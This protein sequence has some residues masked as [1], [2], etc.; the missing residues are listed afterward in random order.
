MKANNT[1]YEYKW[2]TQEKVN[3]TTMATD[4]TDVLGWKEISIGLQN[5]WHEFGREQVE[6]IKSSWSSCYGNEQLTLVNQP[7]NM[8]TWKAKTQAFSPRLMIS[9][10]NNAGGTQNANFSFEYETE[11]KGILPNYWKNWNRFWAD[12]LEV[13][14]DFDL[15]V[16]VLRHVIYNIC[17]KYQTREG[18]FLIEEMSCELF[19]DRIGTTQ[20]KGFKV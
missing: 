8:N 1:F 5:G 7:G 11:G 9:N 6:E 14:G 19:I 10:G 16:N 12:R 4:T 20:I 15:P 3:G 17:S 13:S 18:E 2:I